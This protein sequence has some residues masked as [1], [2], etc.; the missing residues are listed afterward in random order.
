M[1]KRRKVGNLL[2]LAILGT[3]IQRPMHPYE[4]ASILRERGKD[5]DMPIKWGSLYT[6]VRNL[7]KHGF[8]EATGSTRDGGRPER[9]I[10]QI[11]ADGTEELKDWVREL[12]GTPEREQTRFKAA[13][14]M[15][16]ALGPDEA[17]DLLDQRLTLLEAA[18]AADRESLDREQ[19]DLPRLFLIENEYDLAIRSAELVWIRELLAEFRSGAFPG[20]Q[21]WRA[22]HTTGEIPPELREIAERG[23]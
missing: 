10:Y 1:A 19:R 5:E 18:I 21:M 22:F 20:I 13:L 2:A 15:V 7:E 23:K 14:S 11:T 16:G 12:L 17:I 6:V 9:T 8:I 4:M 3:L